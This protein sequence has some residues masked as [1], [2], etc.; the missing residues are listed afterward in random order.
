MTEQSPYAG[1][2]ERPDQSGPPSSCLRR[3]RRRL[4]ERLSGHSRIIFRDQADQEVHFLFDQVD[5]AADRMASS[6]WTERGKRLRRYP[7]QRQGSGERRGTVISILDSCS[8]LSFC[9]DNFFIF[10][11]QRPSTIP[12]KRLSL[13][14]YNVSNAIFHVEAFHDQRRRLTCASLHCASTCHGAHSFRSAG[15]R[16]RAPDDSPLKLPQPEHGILRAIL[17][18]ILVSKLDTYV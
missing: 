11:H 13:A 15:P 17:L 8:V 1:R 3:D 2:V 12:P 10:F 4:G 6:T 14:L 18:P 16:V 9:I 7:L 5:V